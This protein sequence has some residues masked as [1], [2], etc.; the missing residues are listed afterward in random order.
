MDVQYQRS[1]WKT[2][3]AC[4]CQPIIWSMAAIL[5][6]STIAVIAVVRTCPRA[7]P[8]PVITMRKSICEFLFPYMVMGSAWWPFA[9]TPLESFDKLPFE[10]V[11]SFYQGELAI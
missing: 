9:G 7:I 4:L 6:D 10:R 5:R 11:V 8:L 3:A 1:T 2:K